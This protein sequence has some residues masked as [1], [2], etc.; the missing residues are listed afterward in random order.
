MLSY[1]ISMQSA[2]PRLQAEGR[3]HGSN[4]L[5]SLMDKLIQ[6]KGM[7][8][9]ISRFRNSKY[10]SNQR[11]EKDLSIVSRESQLDDKTI[12]KYKRVFIIKVRIVA[13]F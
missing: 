11:N 1:T 2:K 5:G 9:G 8:E 4:I 12:K 3:V 10:I 13:N 6:K 7:E